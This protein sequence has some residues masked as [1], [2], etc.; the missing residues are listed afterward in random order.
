MTKLKVGLTGGIGSG[1]TTVTNLF[2]NLGIEIID[3]DIIARAIVEPNTKALN[4]IVKH[5][6]DKVLTPTG[7]LDRAQL[8]SL[9]FSEPEEKAW[10]NALLHPIIRQEIQS[11]MAIAKGN[12]CIL[13]APLLLE[14]QLN[15]LVDRVVV[16][17]VCEATQIART[18]ARDSSNQQEIEAII[19]SQMSRN[20][21]LLA[22]NDVIDNESTNLD[23]LAKQVAKLHSTY[24]RLSNVK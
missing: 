2:A 24:E 1:K 18:L 15:K 19:A 13:S 6:G 22:A 5:F 20:V 8:R 16:V 14:N 11:A 12:Y 4:S 23:S 7:Q 17:D 3:A 9:I 21:R 10:L